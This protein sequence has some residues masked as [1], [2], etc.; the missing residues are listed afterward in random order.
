MPT[1]CNSRR[2]RQAWPPPPRVPPGRNIFRQNEPLDNPLNFPDP[3]APQPDIPL[4]ADDDVFENGANAAPTIPTVVHVPPEG[5][6][7][8]STPQFN[9]VCGTDGQTYKNL[10][11]LNCIRSC[12]SSK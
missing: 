6:N 3:W 10:G 9:P 7:C 2:V 1:M 11:L 8:P 12:G 5:C 4:E